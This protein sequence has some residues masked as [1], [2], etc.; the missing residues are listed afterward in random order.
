VSDLAFRRRADR[1][2]GGQPLV[3][4]KGVTAN[5]LVNRQEAPITL[6]SAGE[7]H[8]RRRSALIRRTRGWKRRPGARTFVAQ[9]E[10]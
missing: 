1:A 10:I 5:R 8:G 7:I 3:N 4:G 9:T 2:K 6:T